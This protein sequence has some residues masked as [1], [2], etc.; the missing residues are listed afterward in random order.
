MVPECRATKCVKRKRCFLRL[1]SHNLVYYNITCTHGLSTTEQTTDHDR[2]SSC[3]HAK[4]MR[5][6]AWSHH[7][8]LNKPLHFF[9]RKSGRFVIVQGLKTTG[10]CPVLGNNPVLGVTLLFTFVRLLFSPTVYLLLLF[11]SWQYKW[12][13][14]RRASWL[15]I[16]HSLLCVCVRVSHKHNADLDHGPPIFT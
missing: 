7:P 14:A 12:G 10:S 1:Q 13:R 6:R 8:N 3:C 9:A 15:S 2:R 4:H 16:T 5:C 11:L